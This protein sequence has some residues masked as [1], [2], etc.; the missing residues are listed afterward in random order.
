MLGT[1]QRHVHLTLIHEKAQVACQP[2]LV[3][4]DAAY[5]LLWWQTTDRRQHYKV[6]LSTCQLQ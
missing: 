2:L 6:S 5:N 4:C 3:I 1:S